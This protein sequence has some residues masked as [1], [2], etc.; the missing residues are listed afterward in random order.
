MNLAHL[1]LTPPVIPTYDTPFPLG[2][3]LQL[4]PSI[5]MSFFQHPEYCMSLLNLLAM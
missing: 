1:M 4:L 5:I 2:A 3:L